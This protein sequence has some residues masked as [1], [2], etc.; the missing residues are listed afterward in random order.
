MKAR[1]IRE[2][3]QAHGGGI[4]GQK[5]FVEQYLIPLLE[6]RKLPNG[7]EIKRR[8]EDFSI[9]ALWEGMIGPVDET[10]PMGLLSSAGKYHYIR[11]AGGIN[12]TMFPVATGNIITNKVIEA[13]NMDGLIGDMLTT[14]MPSNL[15]SETIPGFTASQG[16]DEVAEGDQYKDSSIGEKYVTTETSKK[17]RLISVTEETILFDRTG[18]ILMRAQKIGEATAQERE[19]AILNGVTGVNPNV[20]KPNGIAT[21]LYAAGNKNILG[22]NGLTDWASIEALEVYHAENVKDDRQGETGEPVLWMP[23]QLLVYPANKYTAK[24]IVSA[25]EIREVT[26]TN[27]TTLSGNPIDTNLAILSSPLMP[28]AGTNT[29]WFYGD[30][31][32]QFGWQEIWPIQTFAQG[33]SSDLA[34]ERDIIARFKVRYY[35]GIFAM[36]TRYVMKSQVASL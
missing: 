4:R 8:P 36:D 21:T 18:E 34:F 15:R 28:T 19:K 27:T 7:A 25:T 17:G 6:G 22:S 9:R 12:S 3:I 23:R 16:P 11:E 20:Y 13:Y 10:L 32:R 30:F 14:R 2:R 33:A 24:R 31:P 26:N 29:D 5:V 35:G 1:E